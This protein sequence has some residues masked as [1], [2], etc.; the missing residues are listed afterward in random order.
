MDTE[1]MPVR[2]LLLFG[3]EAHLS[4]PYMGPGETERVPISQISAD[5][6][7]PRDRLPGAQL[8][9]LLRNGELV[10]FERN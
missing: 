2:I 4:T 7:L 3:E 9:A 1:R 5:T 6:G 8:V 10:R